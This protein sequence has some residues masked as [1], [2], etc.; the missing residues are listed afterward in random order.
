MSESAKNLIGSIQPNRYLKEI[1][2]EGVKSVFRK[3]A[4]YRYPGIVSMY[5]LA[6]DHYEMGLQYAVLAH[7]ELAA[8]L[9]SLDRVLRWTADREHLPVE[10]MFDQFQQQALNIMQRLPERFC[11]EMEGIAEGTGLSI[12]SV[13]LLCLTYDVM[14]SLRCT[15]VLMR[16]EEGRVIH[17]R[18][19]DTAGF[20]GEEMGRLYQVVKYKAAGYNTVT[21]IDFPF[22][23]GVETGY[24]DQ[25]LTFSE[26]T[27]AV[28]KPNPE[29]FSL[30]YLVRIIMEECGSLDELPEYFERY[31]VV[32]AYGTVWSDRRGGRGLVA[33]L[34]PWEWACIDQETPLLWNFN[35]L[36]SNV[37]LPQ[38]KPRVNINPDLDREAIATTFPQKDFYNVDDALDFI[39]LQTGPDGINYAHCASRNAIC[40][41]GATQAVV[42]DPDTQDFYMGV[43]IYYAARQN[44]YR[45]Y[46]DF[47]RQP[48]LFREGAAMKPALVEC[49]RIHNLLLE[50]SE[51]RDQYA[52]LTGRYKDDPQVYYLAAFYS[53]L[54]KT[55]DAYAEYAETAYRL[56]PEVGEYRLFAG[57]A[58]FQGGDPEKAVAL[59]KDLKLVPVE[60]KH[61]PLRLYALQRCYEEIE[62]PEAKRY[63]EELEQFLQQYG[64]HEYFIQTWKPLFDRSDRSAKT[65]ENL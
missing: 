8:Y 46:D 40:N 60:R 3:G 14:M 15:G 16:T 62:S 54:A 30:P 1:S 36:Y 35:H 11:R 43:G 2:T 25:G 21:H 28:N 9:V 22:F 57:L 61:E 17:A 59:L 10:A 13:A 47:S 32:G 42:F 33:E 44:V 38:Q 4:V 12:E 49:A 7:D 18:N 51:Y 20:G 23:M 64:A 24:N 65:E 52:A 45:Y 41:K 5:E 63:K 26:E 58:A 6:G 39:A 50:N 56:A 55:L 29:G 53:F 27:L 37:L 34:T 19:N 31:P 48:A